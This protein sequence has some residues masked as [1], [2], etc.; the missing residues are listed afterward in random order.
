MI[1][2]P[3]LTTI[4]I[5]KHPR[6]KTNE[7]GDYSHI[8]IIH[9]R[10]YSDLIRGEAPD[11]G[12]RHRDRNHEDRGMELHHRCSGSEGRAGDAHRGTGHPDR[13][14]RHPPSW[15]EY[16]PG[17]GAG[18]GLYRQC[19]R[20]AHGFDPGRRAGEPGDTHYPD[21]HPECPDCGRR[22]DRLYTLTSRE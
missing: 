3:I 9:R 7:E 5:S 14:D 16:L 8:G 11:E 4:I 18:C 1:F 17:E 22:C 2:I 6:G 19:L 10:S 20:Q 21:Q 12:V 15:G 13:R